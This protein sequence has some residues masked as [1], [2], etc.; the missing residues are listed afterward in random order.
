MN[1]NATNLKAVVKKMN[2]RKLSNEAW[3][4]KRYEPS[5]KERLIAATTDRIMERIQQL[6]KGKDKCEEL[7]AAIEEAVKS[8]KEM[9]EDLYEDM[10]Y[11]AE[12]GGDSEC[13]PVPMDIDTSDIS[14]NVQ[15]ESKT[16]HYDYNDRIG[17]LEIHKNNAIIER[18]LIDGL[19]HV[20]RPDSNG[21]EV[22][23]M[24]TIRLVATPYGTGRAC[25]IPSTHILSIKNQQKKITK[26]NNSINRLNKQLA[27]KISQW[28]MHAQRTFAA[29]N[30]AGYGCSDDATV[31][32]I[33]GTTAVILQI[34]G[35]E[36]DEDQVSNFSPSPS[37]LA[38]M[39]I[40]LAV[41]CFFGMFWEMKEAGVENVGITTDH[42]HRKGQD[43]L[44]KLLSFPAKKDDG[45]L[46]INFLCLNI[47]SAGHSASEA[48][49]AIAGDVNFILEALSEYVGHKVGLSVITGDAG[50]GASVQ[51]LHPALQAIGIMDDCSKRLS[52]DMHNLNK[53][54]EIACIETW[55][56][57]G[58]G[59]RTPFQMI[60]LFVKILKYVRK[61]FGRAG[62]NRTW[63]RTIDY[64]RNNSRWQKIATN[65]CKIAFNDF[66]DRLNNLEDGDEDD[67]MEAIRMATEAPTNV[68]DPVMTRWGTVLSAVALFAK[69]WVVI[70]FF[71]LTLATNERTNSY[72][73]KL[74]CALVSLMH[75][76]HIPTND[77]ED[78]DT[79]VE[80]SSI[81]SIQTAVDGAE[82]LLEREPP[83]PIFLSVLYFLDAFNKCY[84]G[85]M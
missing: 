72:I 56:K 15:S 78:M 42:G 18:N 67:L 35:I 38:R 27:T 52:C 84:F 43:H 6:N 74:T 83:T 25:W 17:R 41:Q 61:K 75:N 8:D 58:I 49:H 32:I 9:R 26:N 46:T 20:P 5:D 66:I 23:D 28:D 31:S 19:I 10:K 24:Q 65:K 60:W 29:L 64:L 7:R 50:G 69:D 53:A 21:K 16:L 2:K 37:T 57:Q 47:D 4:R 63:S 59:H 80:G 79:F 34:L 85:G 76:N 62:L 73:K 13:C 44:V 71:A 82:K 14:V 68:Q 54:L 48:S 12:L 30:T 36:Y 3:K 77:G 22:K 70:Y 55:G 11:L 33:S 81:E 45:S 1:P 51:N 40:R 39:E